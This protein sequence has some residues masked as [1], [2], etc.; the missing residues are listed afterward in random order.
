MIFFIIAV[1]VGVAAVSPILTHIQ[2]QGIYDSTMILTFEFEDVDEVSSL[3]RLE[4]TVK[5]IMY[6][7]RNSNSFFLTHLLSFPTFIVFYHIL[8]ASLLLQ[9]S[10]TLI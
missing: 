6:K 3:R 5:S 7:L 9:R 2:R 8:T 1:N 10:I 4:S